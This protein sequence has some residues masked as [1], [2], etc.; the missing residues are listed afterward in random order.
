MTSKGSENPTIGT[1]YQIGQDAVALFLSFLRGTKWLPR[2]QEPDFHLDCDV[3]TDEGGEPS[4]QHFGAQVKGK[5]EKDASKVGAVSH[6]F[7]T[8]HL[9]YYVKKCKFPV[10]VFRF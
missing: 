8:K 5:L 9:R 2:K 10:F 6:S 4:G 1:A 7:K 3:E